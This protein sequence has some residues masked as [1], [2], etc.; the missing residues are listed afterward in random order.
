MIENAHLQGM[1]QIYLDQLAMSSRNDSD[2]YTTIRSN[3][4]AKFT[5]KIYEN[6]FGAAKVF[7]KVPTE[8][9]IGTI[10]DSTI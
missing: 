2:Q 9:S 1:N 5:S 6:N 10:K 7:N 3:S 8:S 4:P